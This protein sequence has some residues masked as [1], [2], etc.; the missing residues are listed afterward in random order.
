MDASIEHQERTAR[1]AT[2]AATA[3][4]ATSHRHNPVT[5]ANRLERLGA[6]IRRMERTLAQA[7]AAGYQR[8]D[9]IDRLAIDRADL[10]HVYT[11]PTVVIATRLM[12]P[13]LRVGDGVVRRGCGLGRRG[14]FT[15]ARRVA[16]SS[17]RGLLHGEVTTDSVVPGGVTGKDVHHAQGLSARVP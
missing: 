9:L 13:V 6:D 7:L 17:V 12:P 4:A 8:Q 14:W 11:D 5:V 2:A 15:A 10:E 1:A 16:I 3:A